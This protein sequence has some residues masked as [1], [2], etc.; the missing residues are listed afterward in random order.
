MEENMSSKAS[1]GVDNMSTEGFESNRD[2]YMVYPNKHLGHYSWGSQIYAY[3]HH[4]WQGTVKS[5]EE[6]GSCQPILQGLDGDNY[7]KSESGI[8][9]LNLSEMQKRG[10]FS[11]KLLFKK[12]LTPSDVGRLNRIVIPKKNATTCFPEISRR[13]EEDAKAGVR[14]EVQVDFFDR[15][16]R[17]W[18]FR[19][20]YWKSSQS[21]VFTRGWGRFVKDK[22]LKVNDV[23]AFYMCEVQREGKL[24]NKFLMID[25]DVRVGEEDSGGS[26]SRSSVIEVDDD[27]INVELTQPD[28]VEIKRLGKR[29]M[30]S[31]S[32]TSVKRKGFRLFGVQIN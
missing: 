12:M 25:P 31:E 4:F 24:V 27:H 32:P 30:D 26:S 11:R 10:D 21:Y 5:E 18:K 1:S 9:G 20:C 15:T 29:V 28:D 22:N 17:A 13:M 8:C 19:Y 6:G 23:V 2:C 7:R 14:G 3:S 16:M